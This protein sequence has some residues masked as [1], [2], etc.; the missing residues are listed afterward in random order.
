MLS[1]NPNTMN[2]FDKLYDLLIESGV[3]TEDEISLVCSIN[4][5]NIESLE[6]ILYCRTGYRTTNQWL[7][8]ELNEC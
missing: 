3:A 8:I 2:E 5:R 1:N 6:S 7:E 4:G